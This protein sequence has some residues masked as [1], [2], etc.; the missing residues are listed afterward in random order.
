MSSLHICRRTFVRA[1]SSLLLIL[2]TAVLT[3]LLY[4]TTHSS[5][6]SLSCTRSD[7]DCLPPGGKTA[8]ASTVRGLL[9][10][11]D[12]QQQL[13]CSEQTRMLVELL[14]CTA[15]VDTTFGK[16]FAEWHREGREMVQEAQHNME[17][18]TQLREMNTQL[19]AK[20]ELA[21]ESFEEHWRAGVTW[22]ATRDLPKTVSIAL[23][24]NMYIR[25]NPDLDVQAKVTFNDR[26]YYR[27][28]VGIGG[29]PS[30]PLRGDDVGVAI[31]EFISR[32]SAIL[33]WEGSEVDGALWTHSTAGTVYQLLATAAHPH[34]SRHHMTV[35]YIRP[36]AG[37]HLAHLETVDVR[38]TPVNIIVTVREG[39]LR[40]L[41]RFVRRFVSHAKPSSYPWY[42]TVAKTDLGDSEDQYRTLLASEC[43][44]ADCA[45]LFFLVLP[46]LSTTEV[47]TRAA[48]QL[49]TGDVVTMVTDI[50]NLFDYRFL[51]QCRLQSQRGTQAYLPIAF[52]LYNP[53]VVHFPPPLYSL[54][55]PRYGRWLDPDY[56]TA[57]MY[58][59]DLLALV[60]G[61]SGE[62][63]L[64]QLIQASSLHTVRAPSRHLLRVWHKMECD[65]LWGAGRYQRCLLVKT[66]TL[67]PV[68][69]MGS[70]LLHI[71]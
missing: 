63:E 45:G 41:A 6:Q 70:I 54:L 23:D 49:W 9:K 32:S 52:G 2:F 57:C 21:R 37:L 71:Y 30:N 33:P 3:T 17:R 36:F 14:C 26:H 62:E 12:S 28:V 47:I 59:F 65:G 20:L 18:L 66:H 68:Q 50:Y 22:N 51:Q 13:N 5:L 15:L 16:A 55:S 4:L 1:K 35:H 43:S 19:E 27:P 44:R 67:A 42:L 38:R 40:E 29:H 7:L 10:Q 61:A 25:K 39:Q 24:K 48:S 11:L 60:G 56:S 34:T 64:F 69:K 58:K 8:A 53:R 46:N 31:E